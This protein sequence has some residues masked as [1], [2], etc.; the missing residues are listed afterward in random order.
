MKKRS[1]IF[2][3]TVFWVDTYITSLRKAN[4]ELG[5]FFVHIDNRDV[6]SEKTQ[7]FLLQ[8]EI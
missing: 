1:D 8:H 6:N 5:K 4:P 7:A 2:A 3:L